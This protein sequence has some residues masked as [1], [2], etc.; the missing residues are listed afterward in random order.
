MLISPHEV[1]SSVRN[2]KNTNYILYG[3]TDACLV[4]GYPSEKSPERAKNFTQTSLDKTSDL[5]RVLNIGVHASLWNSKPKI[6]NYLKKH[7]S[8]L[9]WD[10]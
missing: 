5:N 6:H 8:H 3:L 1:S 2:T 7:S 9:P 10:M 4:S